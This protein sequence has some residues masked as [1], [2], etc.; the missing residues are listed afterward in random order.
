MFRRYSFLVFF[1]LILAVSGWWSKQLQSSASNSFGRQ[2]YQQQ[3]PKL[4]GMNEVRQ[5]KTEYAVP[6]VQNH[7]RL[8]LLEFLDR[9]VAYQRY[10]HSI[11]GR[12]TKVL[13]RVGVVVPRKIAEVYEV[14]IVDANDAQLLIV[15]QSDSISGSADV[16]SID[17]DYNL[18]LNFPI[19]KPRAEYLRNQAIKHIRFLK[20]EKNG[21]ITEETGIFRGFFR[22]ETRIDENYNKSVF[23]VGVRHPVSGVQLDGAIDLAKQESSFEKFPADFATEVQ[24]GQ[25]S[26][27]NVMTSV[28]EFH[29]AQRIFRG[30][31]GRHAKNYSEL[32][33]IASFRFDE[34]EKDQK[35]LPA[36]DA[37]PMLEEVDAASFP[38]QQKAQNE[39]SQSLEDLII[40]PVSQ[41][42]LTNIDGVE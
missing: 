17:Q 4:V 3:T 8:E 40:E 23:A 41:D 22:Y 26:H 21:R 42:K 28:E 11:Y 39:V 33:A 6:G 14:R 31:M 27:G 35:R 5:N 2:N 37:L 32:A 12:F 18:Q 15:A 16:V 24:T 34:V 1:A 7:F 9:V 10:Y 13:G 30:E 29:L 38:L 20:D 19:P 36:S 25:R